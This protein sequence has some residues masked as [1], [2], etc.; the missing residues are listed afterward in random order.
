ML[1][2]LFFSIIVMV[3]S[4]TKKEE[5]D[6]LEK[7]KSLLEHKKIN[8]AKKIYIQLAKKG[9]INAHIFLGDAR[10]NNSEKNKL[11]HLK[12]AAKLGHQESLI[13]VL[14]ILLYNANSL[15]NAKP[16]EAYYIYK[17]AKK[18]NPKIILSSVDNEKEEMILQMCSEVPDLN[19]DKFIRKYK[20][21][22]KSDLPHDEIY[23]V[24]ELAEQASR[25]GGR[26]GTP[27]PLLTLQLI[28]RGGR[29]WDEFTAAVYDFYRYW[30][31]NKV[32]EFDI[33]KYITS[34]SGGNYCIQREIPRWERRY[35][36]NL[37]KISTGL[38]KNQI[39]QLNLTFSLCREYL[40]L[41]AWQ[42]EGHDG[43]G[44]IQWIEESIH[45]QI[46]TFFIN[47]EKI[48]NGFIPES[49]PSLKKSKIKLKQVYNQILKL[50][51]N[52]RVR[53]HFSIEEVDIIEV[54]KAWIIYNDQ[55]SKLCSSI[56]KE[57]N[58]D[59]WKSWLTA[60]RIES[61]NEI[62]NLVD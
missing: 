58:I 45:K 31:E 18:A 51:K 16:K 37:N 8:E 39:K 10:Y 56:S 40:K 57:K 49:V 41:K 43:S 59:F 25:K 24:W 6:L 33:C 19:V 44:Y 28:I 50:V 62:K 54:Q 38:T 13:M 53:G 26:F 29:V 17:L 42:E 4:F 35:R 7:A 48:K 52:H 34:G 11:F 3:T 32:V 21:K 30:K 46:N 2:L 14:A 12:E 61:L 9:N 23:N 15:K 5:T 60:S 22:I 36:H 55:M 1:K 20:I 47:L 27:N